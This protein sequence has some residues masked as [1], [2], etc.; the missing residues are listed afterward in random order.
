LEDQESK[1]AG[2]ILLLA[3]RVHS[4]AVVQRGLRQDAVEREC[5]EPATVTP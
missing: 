3:Q 1:V 5:S 2:Q 4:G